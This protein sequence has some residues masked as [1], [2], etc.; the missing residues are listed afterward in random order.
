MLAASR[1]AS[2]Q[3]RSASQQTP[4]CAICSHA[5]AGHAGPRQEQPRAG[6]YVHATTAPPR[7][8]GDPVAGVSSDAAKSN[9]TEDVTCPPRPPVAAVVRHFHPLFDASSPPARTIK[10]AAS[11]DILKSPPLVSPHLRLPT[12]PSP[13]HVAPAHAMA[14]TTC[15]ACWPRLH[16]QRR[17]G[18]GAGQPPPPL[19]LCAQRQ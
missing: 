11:T 7:R 3:T 4:Y 14:G 10:E 2:Q 9:H 16:P 1:S 8:R 13:R 19:R 15:A 17:W 12:I 5:K 6:P 18:T